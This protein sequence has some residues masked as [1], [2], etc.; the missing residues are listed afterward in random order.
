MG[1][2]IGAGCDSASSRCNT[3]TQPA[4]YHSQHAAKNTRSLSFEKS[5]TRNLEIEMVVRS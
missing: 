3:Q 5:A 2:S 4:A 1:Y